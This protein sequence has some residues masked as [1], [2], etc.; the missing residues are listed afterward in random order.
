MQQ[1]IIFDRC[2]QMIRAKSN[3][4]SKASDR[5]YPCLVL[6]NLNHAK[7]SQCDG[8]IERKHRKRSGKRACSRAWKGTGEIME[9]K[10]IPGQTITGEAVM[11]KP[12]NGQAQ[13]APG[14]RASL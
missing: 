3:F 14:Q 6:K 10:K 13:S 7:Y 1:T 2:L 5:G 12:N 9:G 11:M 8:T 4:H